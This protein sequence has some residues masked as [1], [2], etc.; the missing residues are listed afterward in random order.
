MSIQLPTSFEGWLAELGDGLSGADVD[1]L[2]AERDRARELVRKT[3]IPNRKQEA[4]RYTSVAGLLEQGFVQRTEP[5]IAV[6]PQALGPIL[7]PGL[8][9]H[10][11]VLVNGRYE[12]ALS[13]SGELPPGVRAQ[14]LRDMLQRDPGSVAGMLTDICRNGANVFSALN[15][16]GLDDGLVLL[17]EPGVT[18]N[19]PI[20]VIHLSVGREDARVFQPRHLISIGDGARA[21][22]IERYQSLDES[23]YCTNTVLEIRLGNGAALDHQRIQLESPAAFHIAGLYLQQTADSTYRGI[24]L[25]LGARWARTDI[26]TTLLESGA[27]CDLQ[28]L[29]LAGD[30]QLIDY[31]LDVDH[32]APGC[33]SIEGF[34]GILTGKGRAVFDGRI[35]VAKGAQKTDARMSNRNLM[36]SRSAEIDTKPQLEILADDVKCSHG[37]TVGQLDSDALFYLRARGIPL[38]QAKRML[39]MGFA[40]EILDRIN[41]QRLRDRLT[42]LVGERLEKAPAD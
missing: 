1:W 3:G 16:A 31:H 27:V 38:A 22:I 23:L 40:G 35:F 14:G 17:V 15:T 39:S 8:E 33:T 12:P 34:K 32:Q 6:Q 5:D 21:E 24:N 41:D 37:T 7:I 42:E 2:Q 26:H 30:G 9:S 28:G 25:G 20:E 11:I 4:W 13:Q 29:Y 19:R 36:L 18:L 10:R